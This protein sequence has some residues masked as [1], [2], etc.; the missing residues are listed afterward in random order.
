MMVMDDDYVYDEK[1]GNFKQINTQ[2]GKSNS[3]INK[4]NPNS[5][6]KDRVVTFFARLFYA[7]IIFV[8]CCIFCSIVGYI[9]DWSLCEILLLSAFVAIMMAAFE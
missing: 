2:T 3:N 7:L 6:S 9:Y 5:R 8:I 4:E 1:T